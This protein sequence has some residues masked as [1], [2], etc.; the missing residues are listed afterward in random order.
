MAPRCSVFI[1]TSLD[2]FI[3]RPNGAL[4]W[5][6]GSDGQTSKEDY[7]YREFF[8]SIDTLV[9]GRKTYTLA[10][11]FPEW[12]Y[13][14]KRVMVLSS[15]FPATGN[16]LGANVEGVCATPRELMQRLHAEGSRHVYVDGGTTI[17]GFMRAGLVQAL[18]LTRI[19]V[20]LGTGIPLFGP[21]EQDIRL[22]HLSTRSFPNGFVQS[23]Y[24]VEPP[25]GPQR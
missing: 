20:L 25:E 15:R 14:G 3:A 21:V 24:L 7:G 13:A 4:D 11:S 18:T 19:P 23:R 10:T 8:D 17:Q 2:G 1:A 9:I 22:R 16:V 12:P 6:P 5:L